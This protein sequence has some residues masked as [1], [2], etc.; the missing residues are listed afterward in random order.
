M[1]LSLDIHRHKCSA[2]F[3]GA[4]ELAEMLKKM[5][6]TTRKSQIIKTKITNVNF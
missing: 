3:E 6:T 5:I 1:L 4:S 2:Y